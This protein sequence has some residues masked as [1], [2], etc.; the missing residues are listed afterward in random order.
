P[1]EGGA[2][3]L[4]ELRVAASDGVTVGPV[5]NQ[6]HPP[7]G[8]RRPVLACLVGQPHAPVVLLGTAPAG[9][10]DPTSCP[11]ELRAVPPLAPADALHLL[12][13]ERRLAVAPHVAARLA[14][15]L[16]GNAAALTQTA[17]LLTPE[18]LSGGSILPDPLP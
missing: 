10:L 16:G 3:A 5:A 8:L 4:G 6:L 11:F 14:E 2:A 17:A 15:L 18:Q 12:L 1:P 7:D 9:T 13:V